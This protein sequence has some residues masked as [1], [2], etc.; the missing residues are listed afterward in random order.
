[1]IAYLMIKVA[2]M[3]S[4][5][6]STP[7]IPKH[8]ILQLEKLS[9]LLL[10]VCVVILA[11]GIALLI[12][13]RVLEQQREEA[14]SATIFEREMLREFG[15]ADGE[16]AAPDADMVHAAAAQQ[17][18]AVEDSPTVAQ[19]PPTTAEVDVCGGMAALIKKLQAGGLYIATE[20][21]IPLG[22][23]G[24]QAQIVRLQENKIA[25]VIPSYQSEELLAH[26]ARRF[27]FLFVL[28]NDDQVFV[29]QKYQD[30]IADRMSLC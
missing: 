1:M 20:G 9:H 19:P 15:A 7:V 25:L 12:V 28:L 16:A 24:A 23:S 21:T 11:A 4:A 3:A 29:V 6:S 17:E 13:R 8:A 18:A 14:A 27:D 2:T 22:E 10:V 5:A 26:Y 30:F